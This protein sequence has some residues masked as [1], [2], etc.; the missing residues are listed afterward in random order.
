MKMMYLTQAKFRELQ[1]RVNT[2]IIPIGTIEAHGEHLPLGTDVLI[3][4]GIVERI[5][6]KMGDRILVA[7]SVNY[8]HV[9]TL[10]VYPGGVDVPTDLL[11]Q[12]IYHVGRSLLKQGFSHIILMN[13]H[14]GNSPA[15]ST[16]GE[17][18]ADE[19]AVVVTFNWW[20]DFR[21]EI[22]EFCEGQGHAGEDETAAALAVAEAYCDMSR[23]KVNHKTLIANI[24]KQ[25]IGHISYEHGLSGDATKGT[26]EKGE[27]MLDRVAERMMEIIEKVWR[28]EIV[29][30]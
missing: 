23:A 10:G 27:K 20:V 1:K 7:P 29:A 16:V 19:G 21:A 6:A 28:G 3:P 30:E 17:M 22:L 15:L 25:G 12:Y 8:G 5:E 18:L 9:W 13:G 14:G 11:T 4:E 2:V 26:R 24:K